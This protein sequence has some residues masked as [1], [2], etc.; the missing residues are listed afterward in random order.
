M[1]S[2]SRSCQIRLSQVRT[3]KVSEPIVMYLEIN[4]LCS[5]VLKARK[6]FAANAKTG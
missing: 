1:E 3:G 4:Q 6:S 5:Q 2:K